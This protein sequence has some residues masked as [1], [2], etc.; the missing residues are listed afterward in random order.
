MK[1]NTFVKASINGD[2]GE[3]LVSKYLKDYGYQVEEAPKELFYDWDLKGTK[4]GRE[5]TVEVKYDSKAY[6]WAARRGTPEQP[7]LYIEFKSTTR[8]ADSGI[9]KSKAD[10]YFYILKTGKKDIGFVF[11]RKELLAHLQM[12]NY[13]VVGN[14]ATG[15][16]N[17][18]G[19]IPPLHELLVARFGYKATIDL[20]EYGER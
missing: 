6:M 16:D 15:D 1:R 13:K 19:W 3:S 17:A 20:T 4:E 2:Y 11:N 5:V 10:F 9:L 8:D 18:I 14:G 12:A 7:N